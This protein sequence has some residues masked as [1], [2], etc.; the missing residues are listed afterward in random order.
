MQSSL[1]TCHHH[2]PAASNKAVAGDHPAGQ[3]ATGSTYL[4]SRGRRVHK[5]HRENGKEVRKIIGN[6]SCVFF[7]SRGYDI[8]YVT[9][10]TS[11][12]E[13]EPKMRVKMIGRLQQNILNPT[14]SSYLYKHIAIKND[15]DSW[16]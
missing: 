12:Y 2:L 6:S 8:C 9:F 1:A 13:A 11:Q 10:P 3:A 16:L 5:S 7:T 4:P 14:T 15:S